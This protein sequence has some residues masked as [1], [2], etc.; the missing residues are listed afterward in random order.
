MVWQMEEHKH[1]FG[2][3]TYSNSLTGSLGYGSGTGQN[4]DGASL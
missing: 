1:S 2:T 3:K 4:Q